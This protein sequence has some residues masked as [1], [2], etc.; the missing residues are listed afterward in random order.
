MLVRA[1]P[2]GLIVRADAD[3]GWIVVAAA[4]E[5]QGSADDAVALGACDLLEFLAGR[6]DL[7]Q[8]TRSLLD[9]S[10]GDESVSADP[11]AAH[12]PL[13]PRSIRA[14]MVWDSHYTASARMMVKRFFPRPVAALAGG[15]ERL[16]RQ[17]F[18]PFKPN[19]RFY[20]VPSFYIANHTAVLADG[21]PTWWPS[22]TSHLHFQ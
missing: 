22:H 11:A 15:Y 13:Q 20:R 4:A 3:G 21:E 12:L 16:T 2:G 14:F 8:R 18:P 1:T 5:R 17:T 10:R 6:E 19:R 7:E 9:A